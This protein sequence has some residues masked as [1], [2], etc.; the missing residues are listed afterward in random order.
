[1]VS[2]MMD[3][4]AKEVEKVSLRG[5][6]FCGTCA[7]AMSGPV[8]F[9]AVCHC[10]N[11]QRISGG[12]SVHGIGFPPN[13]LQVVKGEENLASFKSTENITRYSCKTCHSPVFI[14]GSDP[15]FAFKSV[16]AGI[17]ERDESGRLNHLKKSATQVKAHL[18]YSR[19][20]ADAPD[21]LPKFSTQM[22]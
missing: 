15:G 3:E 11:C 8:L 12:Q 9:S 16:A 20:V 2:S 5:S 14:E 4:P 18:F 6:C 21:D 17:L 19:R 13:C 7:V 22:H 10:T 1:M